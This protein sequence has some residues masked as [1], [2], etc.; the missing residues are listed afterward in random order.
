MA[1]P[2]ANN[3]LMQFQA[4]LLNCKVIRP[5]ITETTALGAAIWPDS[6]SDSGRIRLKLPGGENQKRY[7]NR[8]CN[9]YRC[10]QE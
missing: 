2:T 8:G 7:L 6:P 4:D 5:E 1:A 10:V 9:L 3:L